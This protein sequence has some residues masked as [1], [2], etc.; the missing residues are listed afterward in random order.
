MF[1]RKLIFRIA[2][3]KPLPC[4]KVRSTWDLID[5]ERIEKNADHLPDQQSVIYFDGE[6]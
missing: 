3:V 1:W 4:I 5:R 6:Y 2:K